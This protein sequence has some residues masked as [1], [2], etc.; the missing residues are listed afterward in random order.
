MKLR[1]VTY[2]VMGKRGRWDGVIG[3]AFEHPNHPGRTFVVG[4]VLIRAGDGV[5]EGDT[6]A[7]RDLATGICVFNPARRRRTRTAA[8]EVAEAVLYTETPEAIQERIDRRIAS[9]VANIL[10]GGGV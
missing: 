9:V 5:R 7:I 3:W 1:K 8:V 6:W 2:S 10:K 4:R